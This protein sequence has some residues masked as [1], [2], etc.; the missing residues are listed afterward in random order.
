MNAAGLM[1]GAV[2]AQP[3]YRDN[4]ALIVS[5]IIG[6]PEWTS[7]GSDEEGLFDFAPGGLTSWAPF[8]GRLQ[9]QN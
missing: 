2:L 7:D 9:Q 3:K 6:P 5:A 8:I 4:G 1:L